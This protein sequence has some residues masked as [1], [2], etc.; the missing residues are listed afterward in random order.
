M[1]RGT[2][3][4]DTSAGSGLIVAAGQQYP[5]TL[6]GIWKSEVPPAIG[7][8]VDVELSG[9]GDVVGISSISDSQIA[10]EQAE[11]ALAA[12]RERTGKLGAG[13]V[14]RFGLWTLIATV[15]L[16]LGWFLLSAVAIQ[17][18]LGKL[19]FT[20]WQVLGLLNSSS[21]LE[22]ALQG[23]RGAGSTGLYGFMA[24]VAFA[25]PFVSYFWSDRRASL[26]GFC[27]YCSF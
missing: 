23:S 11:L 16:L 2:I 20:F 12:A 14:A 18:P 6:E 15:I 24:I 13:A 4:R 8:S 1:V 21:P 22:A 5:F 7:M 19:D 10:R 3:L 17:T 27:R 9:D 25:G 26:A